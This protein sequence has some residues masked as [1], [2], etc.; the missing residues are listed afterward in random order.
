M[1]IVTK[2]PTSL[3]SCIPLNLRLFLSHLEAHLMFPSET[4]YNFAR[5]QSIRL[6]LSVPGLCHRLNSLWKFQLKWVGGLFEQAC[7]KYNL[8]RRQGNDPTLSSPCLQRLTNGEQEPVEGLWPQLNS[9][10]ASPGWYGAPLVLPKG[11]N[12]SYHQVNTS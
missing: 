7:W 12:H 2:E 11:E 8:V 10:P 5:L 6:K 3:F 9:T 1:F 4:I